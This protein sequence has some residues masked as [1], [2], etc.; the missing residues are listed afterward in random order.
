[1]TSSASPSRTPTRGFPLGEP[2]REDVEAAAQLLLRYER[3]APLDGDHAAMFV[4][5]CM[6]PG[7][8]IHRYREL[9]GTVA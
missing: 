9:G 1:V 3:E 2:P 5:M 8:V 4:Q 7:E 6:K